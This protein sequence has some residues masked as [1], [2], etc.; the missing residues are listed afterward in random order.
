MVGNMLIG[1]TKTRREIQKVTLRQSILDAAREIAQTE[2]WNA[3]TIRKVADAIGYS[4]PTLYE[5]FKDKTAL[6]TELNREGFAQLLIAL[7]NSRQKT[8]NPEQTVQ[9]MSLAYCNFAWTHRELYEVMHGLS[10]VLLDESSYHDEAQ[11]VIAEARDAI[12]LWAKAEKLKITNAD[13]A[14]LI[15]WSTLHG[16]ASLAL[17]K[18]MI[19]GKKHAAALAQQAVSDL[20]NAWKA[21]KCI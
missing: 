11:A 14:V 2:G 6:L 9:D 15:L 12:M 13:D 4:H 3:V 20:L 1:A 5:F 18:Q 10:G 16:I 17:A 8:S 7:K 19:G 21:K